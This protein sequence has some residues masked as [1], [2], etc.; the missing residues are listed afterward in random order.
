[1]NLNRLFDQYFWRYSSIPALSYA[2]LVVTLLLIVF[3]TVTDVLQRHRAVLQ[4][5]EV[6]ARFEH[7]AAAASAGTKQ[8]TGDEPDGSPFLDGPTVTVASAALLQ[9][10]TGAIVRAGGSVVSSEVKAQDLHSADG[11]LRITA[12][13]ELEQKALQELLYGIEAEM[14]FLFVDQLLAQAPLPESEGGRIRVV[15]DVSGLWPGTHS[16]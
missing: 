13:C 11:F 5:A 8:A 1:M 7:R 3:S 14:P 6:L 15:L 12:T 16:K 9:R 4:S 2:A 10:V